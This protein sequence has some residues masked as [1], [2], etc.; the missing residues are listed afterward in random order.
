MIGKDHWYN[1]QLSFGSGE[2][3]V[4][5]LYLFVYILCENIYKY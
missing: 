1:S 3:E 5:A 4:F 2:E